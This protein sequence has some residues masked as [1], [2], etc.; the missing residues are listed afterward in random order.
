MLNIYIRFF[1]VQLSVYN[2][3]TKATKQS[4]RVNGKSHL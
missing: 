1:K 4:V 2:T 3:G